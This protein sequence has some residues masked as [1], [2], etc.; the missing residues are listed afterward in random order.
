[1]LFL[2]LL[3]LHL[4][5]RAH[6]NVKCAVHVGFVTVDLCLQYPNIEK[7]LRQIIRRMHGVVETVKESAIKIN[8]N[9]VNKRKHIIFDGCR[10]TSKCMRILYGQ[11]ISYKFTQRKPATTEWKEKK[12]QKTIMLTIFTFTKYNMKRT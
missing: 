2:L 10:E 8:G 4:L 3:D 7:H 1:M 12:P 9:A 5:K 11:R 6:I